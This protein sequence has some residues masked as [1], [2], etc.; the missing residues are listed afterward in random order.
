MAG[1]FWSLLTSLGAGINVF[2]VLYVLVGFALVR[3][4]ALSVLAFLA[5]GGW[6]ALRTVLRI[7]YRDFR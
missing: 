5:L 4:V 1:P 7:V 3:S 2:A 6:D